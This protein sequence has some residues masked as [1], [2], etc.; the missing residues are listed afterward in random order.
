MIA[1]VRDRKT[2]NMYVNAVP[3]FDQMEHYKLDWHRFNLR[4]RLEGKSAVTVEEF[5]KKTGTGRFM[6]AHKTPIL[7]CHPVA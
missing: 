3:I 1:L 4:Q 5:E 6:S 7:L 2:F